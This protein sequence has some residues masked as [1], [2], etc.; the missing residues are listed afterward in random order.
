MQSSRVHLLELPHKAYSFRAHTTKPA[1]LPAASASCWRA[2]FQG[3]R[4][5]RPNARDPFS[6][7]PR[8]YRHSTY[9]LFCTSSAVTKPFWSLVGSPAGT[10]SN[11]LRC[12]VHYCR[13]PPSQF[14]PFQPPTY[15]RHAILF[16]CSSKGHIEPR[17]DS[18]CG[19][20]SL[21]VVPPSLPCLYRTRFGVSLIIL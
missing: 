6:P 11:Q 21:G 2:D 4:A 15:I 12:I 5:S 16:D 19:M 3:V 7:T 13:T 20:R 1:K 14:T 17:W 8:Q 9:I 10:A 18:A